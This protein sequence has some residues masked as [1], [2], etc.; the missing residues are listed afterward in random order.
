VRTLARRLPPLLLVSSVVIA[1]GVLP[2]AGT[3]LANELRDLDN[4]LVAS[5]AYDS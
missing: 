1:C 5:V 2:D 4:P 3:A